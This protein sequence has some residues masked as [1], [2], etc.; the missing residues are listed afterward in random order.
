MHLQHT[1]QLLKCTARLLQGNL[2][3]RLITFPK[4][5]SQRTIA[6]L[7]VPHLSS[8][9]PAGSL[10][11][12]TSVLGASAS[13]LILRYMYAVLHSWSPID[14]AVGKGPVIVV[15]SWLRES[16]NWKD[17]GKRLVSATTCS[18]SGFP[19][20]CLRRLHTMI[21]LRPVKRS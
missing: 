19:T 21:F 15:I 7:L 18:P 2:H 1:I 3:G 14:S 6:P 20:P 10:T 13:W 16:D 8:V 12:V 5:P 9:P 4:M 17:G 11:L